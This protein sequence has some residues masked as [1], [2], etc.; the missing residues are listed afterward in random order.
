MLTVARDLVCHLFPRTHSTLENCFA[1][2]LCHVHCF[3]LQMAF[4]MFFVSDYFLLYQE[5]H[6][7]TNKIHHTIGIK[8]NQMF[9]I[10]FY[11][12]FWWKDDSENFHQ[13]NNKFVIQLQLSA[14]NQRYYLDPELKKGFNLFKKHFPC[15][16]NNGSLHC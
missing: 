5:N 13:I 14:I 11:R 7:T 4:M 12:Y 10:V 16:V 1:H 15:I 8:Y 9:Q 2:L 3:S 6:N